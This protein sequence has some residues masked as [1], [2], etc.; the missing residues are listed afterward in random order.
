L[1]PSGCT[2]HSHATHVHHCCFICRCMASIGH[3]GSTHIPGCVGSP[4]HGAGVPSL[5][6]RPNC[7]N[8][9]KTLLCCLE[10]GYFRACL[11]NSHCKCM[12]SHE[13]VGSTRIPERVGS[14]DHR[15][16]VHSL[17]KR[18]NCRN[19]TKTLLCCLEFGYFRACLG[20]SQFRCM[21]SHEHGGSTRIPERV[22]SPDHGAGVHSLVKRSVCRHLLQTLI[23]C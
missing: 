5:V 3:A 17:V 19:L 22:G 12:A 4:D 18:P 11:G 2:T 23:G 21:A 1:I 13:H 7:R 8:P 15:A 14:P 10:F 9:T 6:K 20:N 16:G